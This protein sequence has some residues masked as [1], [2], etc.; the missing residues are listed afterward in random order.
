M[1]SYVVRAV[2]KHGH[3]SAFVEAFRAWREAA[4]AAGLPAYRLFESDWGTYGE[5]FASAQFEDIGDIDR[6]I[7]AAAATRA[8]EAAH[9]AVLSH[10]VDGEMRDYAL[11]EIALE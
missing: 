3:H 11:L 7:S 10:L 2:V 6:R 1:V 4:V 5:V 9:D 8:Y